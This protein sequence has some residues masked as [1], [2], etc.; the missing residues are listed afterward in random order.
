MVSAQ[1]VFQIIFPV[2]LLQLA[3]PLP[4]QWGLIYNSSWYFCFLSNGL[5]QIEQDLSF[6]RNRV[7]YLIC[8]KLH[9]KYCLVIFWHYKMLLV[10][11]CIMFALLINLIL[12]YL[13]INGKSTYLRKRNYLVTFSL[14]LLSGLDNGSIYCKY[15][16]FIFLVLISE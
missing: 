9:F 4:W 11:L 2:S 7:G 14:L 6:Y 13:R 16:C 5:R 1:E 3:L 15:I 10:N 8:Y 12:I